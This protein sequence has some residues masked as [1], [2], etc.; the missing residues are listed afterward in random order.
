M[1]SFL[2]APGL[3]CLKPGVTVTATRAQVPWKKSDDAQRY[4]DGLRKTGL[5]E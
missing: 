3:P 2:V 1:C 5:P 4:L